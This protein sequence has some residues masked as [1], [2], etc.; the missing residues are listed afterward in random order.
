MKNIALALLA[1]SSLPFAPVASR[2]AE[3]K[4]AEAP[5][6]YFVSPKNNDTVDPEFTVKFG[7]KGMEIKPAGDLSAGTGHHH[8]VINGGPIPK[9]Q[10]IPAD[11][12]HLHFGKG[13][14]ETKVSLPPGKHTLTLQFADGKHAS[15][16]EE[17]SSTITV[18][19]RDKAA[20]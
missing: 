4:K 10:I 3:T 2:A 16:G 17:M 5:K 6:V 12:K 14:T 13:Q 18:N 8:L 19:V 11:D 7:L 1:L 20:K 15:Y 9:G